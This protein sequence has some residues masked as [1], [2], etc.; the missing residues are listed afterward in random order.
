MPT[1]TLNKKDMLNLMKGKKDKRVVW[2]DCLAYCAPSGRQMKFISYFKGT[3]VDKVGINKYRK[4]YGMI[5]ALFMPN[6]FTKTLS[7]IPTKEYLQYWSGHQNNDSFKKLLKY[8]KD[9]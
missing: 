1:I 5:D 2:K 7:E 3:F 9:K 8:L 6:G 4:D